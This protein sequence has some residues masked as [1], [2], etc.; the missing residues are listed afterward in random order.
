MEIQIG[1]RLQRLRRQRLESRK[2]QRPATDH[3]AG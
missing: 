3:P 1:E 2:A